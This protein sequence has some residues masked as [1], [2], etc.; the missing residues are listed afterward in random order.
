MT[1][2]LDPAVTR[3][4]WAAFVDRALRRARDNGISDRKIQDLSGVATSTFHRW[5]K[6]DNKGLP[7]LPQVRAF[8]AAAGAD[9]DEAMRV[10]GMTS[11]APS[12][13]PEPP[14]P[15]DVRIIMRRLADPNTSEIDKQFI[16]MS[17][18][19]L[20]ARLPSGADAPLEDA[21]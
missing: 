19:M 18:R 8:C 20:A 15:E 14:L 11:S 4:R 16:R 3:A 2:P 6:G 7:K 12:F 17:L 1:E 5:R 10:L 13:T 9:L 21:G